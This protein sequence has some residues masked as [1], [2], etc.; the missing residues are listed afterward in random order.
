[1]TIGH[2]RG[3]TPRSMPFQG[4]GAS[5]EE[6]IQWIQSAQD[7]AHNKATVIDSKIEAVNGSVKELTKELAE[8]GTK[9]AILKNDVGYIRDGINEIKGAQ[10]TEAA[11]LAMQSQ[12]A[13]RMH[14][15]QTELTDKIDTAIRAHE[16]RASTGRRWVIGLLIATIVSLV[17]IAVSGILAYLRLKG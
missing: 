4:G 13:Q 10:I 5:I 8:H 17:G 11:L 7:V 9:L 6:Q 2:A 12:M 14:A 16:D 3:S 1:M 15:M